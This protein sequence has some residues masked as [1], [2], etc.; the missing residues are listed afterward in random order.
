ML[1]V[2]LAVAGIT[3]CFPLGVL[4]ALGRRSKLPLMRWL[5]VV[6]IELFRG[7][8]LYVLLLLAYFVV[9]LFLPSSTRQPE[10]RRPGDRRDDAVHR[11]VHR[12][13]R[14]R[15]PAVAAEGADRGGAGARAVDRCARRS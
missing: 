1:N 13:D 14:P 5:C 12:R 8:P 4:L 7:V 6:Y 10:P 2:F 11:G 9:P 15:R 3:L